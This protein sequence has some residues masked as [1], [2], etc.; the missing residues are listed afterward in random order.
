VAR[1]RPA[2]SYDVAVPVPR[3]WPDDDVRYVHLSASY[4]AAAAAARVRGWT[5]VGDGTGPH[6]DVA[7]APAAS[8]TCSAER[9]HP[10][11]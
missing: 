1:R 2:D 7:E 8:H 6:L 3:E 11:G 9:A 4:D 5:V 10:W